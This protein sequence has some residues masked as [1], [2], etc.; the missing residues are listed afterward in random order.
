MMARVSEEADPWALGIV[1]S[2]RRWEWYSD[3]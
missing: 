3:V 2:L 1:L